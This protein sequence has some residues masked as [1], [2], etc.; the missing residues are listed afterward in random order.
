MPDMFKVAIGKGGAMRN[1]NI[2][3]AL[4]TQNLYCVVQACCLFLFFIKKLRCVTFFLLDILL[5]PASALEL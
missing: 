1:V 4:K 5:I 2:W 3:P